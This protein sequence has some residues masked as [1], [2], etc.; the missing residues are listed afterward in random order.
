MIMSFRNRCFLAALAGFSLALAAIAGQPKPGDT[1]PSLT[2]FKLEGA[3]PDLASGKVVLIDFW[4]SWCGPCKASFPAMADLQKRYGEKGLVVLAVNVDERAEAMA[5]FLKRNPA[6]FAVL[7]DANHKLVE[8]VNVAT[9]P[10]S[11]LLDRQGVVRFV[12]NGFRGKETVHDY[13]REI[14][15]LLSARP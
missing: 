10:T 13:E 15:L 14:E 8:K 2:E 12:H 11:F 9:L 7:R 4:A 1:F 6:G 3:L 5:A